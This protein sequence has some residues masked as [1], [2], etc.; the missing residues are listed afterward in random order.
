M[1]HLVI[2][3][4][5]GSIKRTEGRLVSPPSDGKKKILHTCQNHL[6]M[7]AN[8]LKLHTLKPIGRLHGHRACPSHLVLIQPPTIVE[9]ASRELVDVLVSS[10]ISRKRTA[11]SLAS[12]GTCY[13]GETANPA[14]EGV[15]KC[16]QGGCETVWVRNLCKVSL[17]Y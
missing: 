16:Q 9:S 13:C 3:G 15:V 14:V 5:P 6:K 11:I 7:N 2:K 17:Y 10:I 12:L 1:T 8:R 4:A